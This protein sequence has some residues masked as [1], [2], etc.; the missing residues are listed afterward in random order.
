MSEL[1]GKKLKAKSRRALDENGQWVTWVPEEGSGDKLEPR[2]A[3]IKAASK[4]KELADQG[5]QL[6][7]SDLSDSEIEGELARRKESRKLAAKPEGTEP[8]EKPIAKMTVKD[9]EAY[10]KEK[11]VEIPEGSKKP[12][13]VALALEA[14]EES[15]L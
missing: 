5:L 12:E 7:I 9:L 1:K 8:A 2:A 13:L 11:N 3:A 6:G 14:E 15:D 4:R 10:L